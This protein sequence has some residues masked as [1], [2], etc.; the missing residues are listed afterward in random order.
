MTKP[1]RILLVN[2]FAPS[3]SAE[4]ARNDATELYR[5]VESLG[6]AVVV[7]MIHQR[8]YPAKAAYIGR[9]KAQEVAEKIKTLDIDTVV[10]N[11]MAKPRQLYA[12]WQTLSEVKK[13]I[14]VWDRIDLIL[15]I[16]SRHA[17]TSEAKL[18]IELAQ[19]RHMGPRIYGMGK[20]LSQQAGGIG[21]RGIG[22]TNVELM[23][24]HWRDAMQGVKQKLLKLQ[25][26]REMQIQKRKQSGKASISII[27]YTNAGKTS[28]FHILT[29]KEKRG[30][31]ILFATLDST[32]GTLYLPRLHKE[33]FVSDT[34]GFIKN[35]PP[36]L[37]EAFRSTLLES[38]HADIILHILDG[39]SPTMMEQFRVVE[40]IVKDLDLSEK[41]ELFIV[42]KVDQMTEAQQRDV[43][44]KLKYVRPLF[45]SAKTSEGIDSLIQEIETFLTVQ[46]NLRKQQQKI[47]MP[48]EALTFPTRDEISIGAAVAIVQKQDQESGLR[49]TGKVKRIL[50]HGF[51][52]PRGIKV[53]L[54]EG[55]IGRVKQLV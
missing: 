27:G 42:N 44:K 11:G 30:E 33:V 21:T 19:I 39:S 50:S 35:L 12:L 28:L 2:L 43:V 37:I 52:H 5:L 18:Q 26:Q 46:E 51:S 47:E 55:Y 38:I 53:A 23:K 40:Q 17:Q 20:V 15:H 10:L 29:K 14:Q 45:L 48:E 41:D 34:I 3:L 6:D 36:S 8:G 16:F 1:L 7:D 24:R 49:T 25:K 9:G 54:E 13:D 32:V 22:E 4:Q 31:N